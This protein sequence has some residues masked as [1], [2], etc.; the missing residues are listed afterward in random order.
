MFGSVLAGTAPRRGDSDAARSRAP[1]ELV[2]LDA[3]PIQPDITLN[4]RFR[5][6]VGSRSAS[7]SSSAN[8]MP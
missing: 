6:L 8:G 4:R 1:A 5:E 3:H 2:V 7:I